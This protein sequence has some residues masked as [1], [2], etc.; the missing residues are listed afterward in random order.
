LAFSRRIGRSRFTLILLIL[1]SVT[2]LT[3]DFHGFGPI[4]SARSGALSVFAPVGDGAASLFKPV[5]NFWHGA[6]QYDDLKRQNDELQAQVD[7]LHGQ[8]TSG[9]VAKQ[10]LQQLLEQANLPFVGD[11]PTT[12]ARVVSGAVANFD[13]TIE[14]DKGSN[15]GIKNDMP[16]VVGTGLVGSVVRVSND[17]S[18]IK[19]ITDTRFAVGVSVVGS[20]LNN[21]PVQAVARGQGS[22]RQLH[23]TMDAGS[24]VK[25]GQ[26]L[27]TAGVA[28][29]LFP[30]DLPVGTVAAVSNDEA[31][32]QTS[33]SIDL[34]ANLQNLTYVSVVLWTGAS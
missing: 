20:S 9:D 30:A 18:V 11:L 2:L 22:G 14:I 28:K 21:A 6:F 29:G 13:D 33:L 16:V 3:L 24:L 15:D 26:I 19:L 25:P 5:G 7:E 10:S 34:L 27:V 4:D 32:L 12:R 31:N 23:A 17:R 1:T 8:I